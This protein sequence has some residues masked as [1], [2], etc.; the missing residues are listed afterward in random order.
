V[1]KQIE[2]KDWSRPYVREM[3]QRKARVIYNGVPVGKYQKYVVDA[4]Y[5]SMDAILSQQK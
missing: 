4:L 3:V 2:Y 5:Q 1:Y